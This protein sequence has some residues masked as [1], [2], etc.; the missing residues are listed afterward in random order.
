MNFQDELNSA[1]SS[2]KGAQAV[3]L[4]GFDG[5]PVAEAKLENASTVFTET[6]VEYTQ[7][8]NEAKK[9]AQA[10]TLGAFREMVISTEKFRFLFRVVADGY[11]LGFLLDET[12]VLGKGR[13]VLRRLTPVIQGGL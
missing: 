7:L 2:V 3:V 11:F 5:I 1:L 10:G 4:M 13:F 8:L 12:S 6:A 9:I